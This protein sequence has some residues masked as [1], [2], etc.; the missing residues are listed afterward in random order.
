MAPAERE[1]LH[2]ESARALIALGASSEDVAG[3]LL[4]CRPHE[5]PESSDWLGR[6]R[7]APRGGARRAQQSPTSSGRSTSGR[8]GTTAA[9][10][11]PT[12]RRPSSTP[13]GPTRASGLRDAL[14]ELPRRPPSGSTCLRD[15]PSTTFFGADDARNCSRASSTP[16]ADRRRVCSTRSSRSPSAMRA[17]TARGRDRR[18]PRATRSFAASA[19]PPGMARHRARHRRRRACAAMALEALD[20]GFL[21]REARRRAAYH[22]CIAVLI[23]TDRAG[24]ARRAIAALRDRGDR[25]RIHAAAR[26]GGR[27]YA[28]ELSLRSGHVREAEAHARDALELAGGSPAAC[29]PTTATR[30]AGGRPRPSEASST[31][32]ASCSAPTLRSTPYARTT[33]AGRGRFRACPRRRCDAGARDDA[34]RRTRPAPA[35]V[36]PHRSR[37]PTSAAARRPSSLAET[38]LALADRFGAPVADR[39]GACSRAPSSEPDDQARVRSAGGRWRS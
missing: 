26:R 13:A 29:S 35:G 1:R 37:S 38:E 5:D 12:W 9:G 16:A 39:P 22:L 31:R 6:P 3:H 4:H 2:R 23:K 34:G 32:P 36:R 15:S 28:A 20:G 8:P 10:S 25:P 27:A 24:D 21:L 19:R 17:R 11:S 14:A 18:S 7:P 30:V 33:G